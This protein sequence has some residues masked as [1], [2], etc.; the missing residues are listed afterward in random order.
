VERDVTELF[1]RELV[2]CI[3]D[4]RSPSND[5]LGALTEK[6]WKE[7]I[8]FWN[9]S[10][11]GVAIKAAAVAFSGAQSMRCPSLDR[12]LDREQERRAA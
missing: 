3:R 8:S 10:P 4:G 9:A 7:S 11:P 12:D 1:P 5:E 2:A 6:L